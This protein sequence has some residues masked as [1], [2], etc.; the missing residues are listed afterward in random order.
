MD[1]TFSVVSVIKEDAQ[2]LRTFYAYYVA[3]GAER[4]RIYFDG[5]SPIAADELPANVEIIEIPDSLRDEVPGTNRNDHIALQRHIFTR[6]QRN[7]QSDWLLVVDADEF[8]TADCRLD[9]LFA[10]LPSGLASLRFPVGEAVWQEGDDADQP[11]G[12]STFR[13]SLGPLRHVL[14]ASLLYGRL[15]GLFRRGVLGHY[16]GKHA[17]RRGQEVTVVRCHH[18]ELDGKALG[19]WTPEVGLGHVFVAHFDAID[20]RR[21]V[22]KLHSRAVGPK[23]N[24]GMSSSRR[25]QVQMVKQ[26]VDGG[27]TEALFRSLYGL[28]ARQFRMLRL[29]GGL[30]H[31]P[32]LSASLRALA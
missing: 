30:K 1:Q 27:T 18:S 2:I 29:F 5:Q 12:A 21:W 13:F 15:A 22:D 32:S 24:F 8:V 26:A 23:K 14:L 7:V 17:V 6:E 31:D 16:A 3:Q 10:D 19:K 9:R 4:V 25:R 28:S 20:R 11:F